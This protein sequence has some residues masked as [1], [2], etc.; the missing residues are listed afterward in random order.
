MASSS[1]VATQ[2]RGYLLVFGT[3]LVLT[4]VTVAV[5]Y[6]HLPA[7]SGITVGLLIATAKAS[8]VAAIF[9]HLRHE[10]SLIVGTMAATVF[11]ALF[12]LLFTVGSEHGKAPGTRFGAPYSEIPAPAQTPAQEAH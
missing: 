8:L 4:L 3:L 7:A 2:V 5:S 9:M 10:R 6:L 11:F 1:D 12:M